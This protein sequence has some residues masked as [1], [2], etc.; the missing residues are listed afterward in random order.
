MIVYTI[1]W[2]ILSLFYY[3]TTLQLVFYPGTQPYHQTG[4]RFN[5]TAWVVTTQDPSER[6]LT[7][8]PYT[9]DWNTLA[10]S[11]VD[12]YLGVDNNIA[13]PLDLLTVEVNDADMNYILT[14]RN[15]SRLEKT[16]LNYLVSTKI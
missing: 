1:G 9:K 2:L 5:N 15:I 3:V 7:Y 12:F 10:P 16:N 4:F 6:Y 11:R 14:S 13:D 8:G